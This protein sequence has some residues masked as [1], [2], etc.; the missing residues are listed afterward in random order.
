MNANQVKQLS[1]IFTKLVISSEQLEKRSDQVNLRSSQAEQALISAKNALSNKM[2]DVESRIKSTT[3]E[4]IEQAIERPTKNFKNQI[5][6]ITNDVKTT[7][8]EL[9][10][11]QRDTGKWLNALLWKVLTIIGLATVLAIGA[12]WFV[13]AGAEQ[14]IK[15]T[16]WIGEI[17][18][19][20]DKGKLAACPDQG[21]CAVV[22][23]KLIRLDK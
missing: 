13:Y 22:D 18:S 6:T 19:A 4:T 2:M 7:F 3:S 15:R 16:E 5:Q 12:I 11:Q 21:V 1:D 8:G 23:K 17:N 14:K 9:Q 10:Q 20:I